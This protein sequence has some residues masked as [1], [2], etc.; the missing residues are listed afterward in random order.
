MHKVMRVSI[1]ILVLVAALIVAIAWLFA[2]ML[3]QSTMKTA[4]QIWLENQIFIAT[5]VALAAAAMAARPVYMQVRAQ[6][7]TAALDLLHRL[8]AESQANV[9]AHQRLYDLR[10][11]VVALSGEIDAYAK[12]LDT[13]GLKSTITGLL[14]FYAR[15][16]RAYSD[17]PTIAAAERTKLVA[18]SAVLSMTQQVAVELLTTEKDGQIP[19]EAVAAEQSF[20]ATKLA[21]LFSLASEIAEDLEAQEEQKR[22]RAAQLREAANTAWV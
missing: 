11:A 14:S 2:E 5:I 9:D 21:G 13:P 18:L 22:E 19:P 1:F 6:S 12:D 20:I 16:I 8:E 3:D 4:Y 17:R 7:V 10:R 15:E